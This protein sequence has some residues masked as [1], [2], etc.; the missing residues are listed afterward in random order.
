M[1]MSTEATRY[2]SV[3]PQLYLKLLN[4]TPDLF[5]I[6]SLMAY[7]TNYTF[8][9]P[10]PIIIL[11]LNSALSFLFNLCTILGIGDLALA[12]FCGITC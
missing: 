3:Y 7:L 1:K 4:E 5:I 10:P 6:S 9:V 11:L 8:H 12:L 2:I